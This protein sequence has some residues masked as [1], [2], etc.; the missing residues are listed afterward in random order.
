MNRDWHDMSLTE[1]AAAI[2][3]KLSGDGDGHGEGT[4]AEVDHAIPSHPVIRIRTDNR[5]DG[6]GG[7]GGGGESDSR[8]PWT[9]V[10]GQGWTNPAVQVGTS[11]YT[12]SSYFSGLSSTTDG[13]YYLKVDVSTNEFTVTTDGSSSSDGASVCRIFIGTV[14]DGEQ[15]EGIY[16]MPVIWAYM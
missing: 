9:F 5:D 1:L 4:R 7:G 3:D 12:A 2:F 11:C 14:E 16:T 8:S 10:A 13:T 6:G 15:T